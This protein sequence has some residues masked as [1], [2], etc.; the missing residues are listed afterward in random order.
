MSFPS[1]T[2][3]W[4][5]GALLQ[6]DLSVTGFLS[7]PA[8][9]RT[10]AMNT[11]K[12]H[13]RATTMPFCHSANII[14]KCHRPSADHR[15]VSNGPPSAQGALHWAR[16]SCATT[17]IIAKT[18]RVIPRTMVLPPDGFLAGC[19]HWFG[20][21]SGIKRSTRARFRLPSC[22]YGPPIATTACGWGSACGTAIGGPRS[23]GE[24]CGDV[25]TNSQVF[26]CQSGRDPLVRSLRFKPRKGQLR[27]AVRCPPLQRARQPEL[28]CRG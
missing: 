3:R 13:R 20:S 28:R 22:P 4:K 1:A 7:N 2:H 12:Y 18:R 11:Q 5:T 15:S 14:K 25:P 17:A 27:S 9:A 21:F 10:G 23:C 8:A 24:P 26:L 16:G 6:Q 19:S